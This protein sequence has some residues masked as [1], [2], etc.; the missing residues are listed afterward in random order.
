MLAMNGTFATRVEYTGDKTVLDN[1][2][3]FAV[4]LEYIKDGRYVSLFGDAQPFSASTKWCPGRSE[5]VYLKMCNNEQFPVNCTLALN[6]AENGFDE[7][8]QY[9]ILPA[10]LS[11]GEV[12]HPASWSEFVQATQKNATVLAQGAHLLMDEKTP[13]NP[14]ET[15]CLA[16]C[17]HMNEGADSSYQNKKLSMD[18]SLRLDADFEP[19]VDPN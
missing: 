13:L 1:S 15:K 8:L 6:V 18:F 9:A 19:G 7:Q 10:D 14:G 4:S 16:L 2:K 3:N 12:Q 17:I 11:S 5:I